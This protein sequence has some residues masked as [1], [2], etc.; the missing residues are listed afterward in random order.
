MSLEEKAVVSLWYHSLSSLEESVLSLLESVL[1]NTG[2]TP[3]RLEQQVAQSLL[4]GNVCIRIHLKK[5]KKRKLEKDTLMH[6]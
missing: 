5:K 6:F 2:P 1:A 3:Q 4:V